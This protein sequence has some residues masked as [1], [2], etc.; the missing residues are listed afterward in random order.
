LHQSV[1]FGLGSPRQTL[2][3]GS[4]SERFSIPVAQKLQTI[5]FPTYDGG[6]AST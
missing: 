1:A 2:D 3:F 6:F 4:R 5:P